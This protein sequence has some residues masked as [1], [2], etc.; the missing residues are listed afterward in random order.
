MRIATVLTAAACLLAAGGCSSPDY[1]EIEPKDLSFTRRGETTR[2]RIIAKSRQGQTFPGAKA[3]W[4]SSNEA[5]FK[6]D[7]T[8]LIET[9]GPGR[10]MLIARHG[11]LEAEAQVE[12]V[13]VEKI[14]VEPL[15]LELDMETGSKSLTVVAFDHQGR[16]LKG[17]NRPRSK[18]ADENVCTAAEES[19]FPSNPGTTVLTVAV[20]GHQVEIPVTVTEK[21]KRRR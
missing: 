13:T 6:V 14:S 16:A 18:C 4:K 12:V 2:A 15:A 8:G 17:R 10:A 9:V 19:V 5:V 21:P 7:E 20:E 11:K 3:S 1:I